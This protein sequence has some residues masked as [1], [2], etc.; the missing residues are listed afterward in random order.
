MKPLRYFIF[1]L[2]LV[3]PGVSE[4]ALQTSG[5]GEIL[6]IRVADAINPVT[7]RFIEEQ[8]Q[9][10]NQQRAAAFLL[11]LDTPGGLVAAM[12]TIV[13]AQLASDVPVIVYVSPSGGGAASAGALI[14]MAADFAVMAPGTNIGAA[15]PVALG[16]GGG[17]GQMD[18]TMKAKVFNDFVAYS[19]SIAEQRGRNVEW[20]EEIV[21]DA[22]SSSAEE[23]LE[24]KVVD[25][26][27][28]SIPEMVEALD[29]KNYLR[30]GKVRTLEIRGASIRL[31]EMDWRLQLLSA[32]SNPTV[33][34][35]LLMLG[36]LGIFFEISQPGVILPGVVGGIALLLA[37]FGLQMLPV[38]M[39]GVLLLMLA[40]VLF[41][42]EITV[43]SYGMLSVG[44]VLSLT[45]GSLILIDSDEPWLQISRAVIFATVAVSSTFSLLVVYFITRTQNAPIFSGH[46]G[47]TGET[48][49]VVQ[50]IDGEGRV[51]VHGEYWRARSEQPI[52]KG[53]EIEVIR[54][55]QGLVVWVSPLPDLT[56]RADGEPEGGTE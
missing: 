55:E 40:M 23:A 1:F 53:T 46:E 4:G 38:N 28:E 30:S 15:S 47:M 35:L 32:L 49:R 37:F 18:E 24:L 34:Y 39:I 31:V 26:V 14:T 3:L 36:M 25:L 20:A 51:F 56:D 13:Q 44:G 17:G 12:R 6:H 16:P 5:P 22:R 11:S 7:A 43:S 54:V 33:A 27:A 8:L 9:V 52:P 50:A 21:R 42:L 19:R 48:G 41:I 45:L 29:G 10:A 2:C